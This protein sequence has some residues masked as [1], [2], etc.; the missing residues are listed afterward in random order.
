MHPNPGRTARKIR[1][2]PD[3]LDRGTDRGE[4]TMCLHD[5]AEVGEILDGKAGAISDREHRAV[6]Q[7]EQRDDP[8][9]NGWTSGDPSVVSHRY[10]RRRN[11]H[12]ESDATLVTWDNIAH[13]VARN[14]PVAASNSPLAIDRV[15]CCTGKCRYQDRPENGFRSQSTIHTENGRF[16]SRKPLHHAILS[17]SPSECR[18]MTQSHQTEFVRNANSSTR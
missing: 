16:Q 6:L 11:K 8:R 14:R 1:S 13:P 12:S 2:V 9:I 17:F 4:I 5:A 10:R 7:R 3:Y 15:S 18:A